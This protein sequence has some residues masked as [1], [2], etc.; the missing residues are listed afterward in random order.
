MNTFNVSVCMAT[1]NGL[2]YL[3]EQLAS[4]LIQ[5]NTNDELVIVDD[6]SNDGTFD[7]LK[8]IS[9]PRVRV[10]SNASNLGHVKSFEKALGLARG[11]F[12]LMADQDDVWLDGRLHNMR[13]ALEA[14]VALVSTN[15]EFMDGEGR[16]IPPLHPDL[17]AEDSSFHFLNIF[18]IFIGNAYYDGCAMGLRAELL[19]IV[20]PIPS[21]VE[22]HDLWIAM[23]A[24]AIGSNLHLASPT[25]RRR[26]HGGNASV[27]SR[28]FVRKIL[29]RIVFLLSLFHIVFRIF[30]Q[31]LTIDRTNS[32]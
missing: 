10:I 4:I 26:V 7:Y 15:S 16:V 25:L 20:L 24:N 21:Y 18:L 28:P 32:K 11:R 13:D 12:I 9:D 3:G 23:A 6:A 17:Y 2:L 1:Y 31:R 27:V 8:K 29:S 5:M 19:G 22:S 30:K 14:G